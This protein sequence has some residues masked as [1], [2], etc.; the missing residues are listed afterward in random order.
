MGGRSFPRGLQTRSGP[1]GIMTSS[2]KAAGRVM[3]RAIFVALGT[4]VV[5]T[6]AAALDIG[7]ASVAPPSA[8]MH[9]AVHASRARDAARREQRIRIQAR[10]AAA[11][12][13]C[14]ALAGK[15][16]EKCI[17]EAHA[18]RGR[19]MLEAAAPYQVRL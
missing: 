5:I 15:S 8:G 1:P 17:V 3:K 10:Y 19:A 14:T 6:S 9:A 13:R 16:R 7:A 4:V 12:A 18:A 11:R 2:G